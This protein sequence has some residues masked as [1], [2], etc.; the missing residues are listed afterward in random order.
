MLKHHEESLRIMVDH[1]KKNPD[2]LAVVFGGSVAKGCERANSDLDAM[3]IIT[4]EAYR[5][6]TENNTTTETIHGLCTYEGGYFDVKYMTKEYLISAAEKGSEPTRSSFASSRVMYTTD[7]EIP[8]I[9]NRIPVFQESE[10]EDKMLSFFSDFWLNYYYF[11]KSCP[12]DD[13]M[14]V[15]VINE[16]VYSIY[17]MILQQNH[18]LF[19]CN[20]RLGE[21]I[22]QAADT[23]EGIT[24]LAA[25]LISRMDNDSMDAFVNAFLQ[26]SKYKGP[27]DISHVLSRYTNDFEQWWRVPRPLIA[28]W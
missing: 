28:E 3:I 11:W 7:A 20:R 12:L 23:P 15:H 6:R 4:E 19:P 21:Y 10:Y 24:V 2:V 9:V 25:E 8:D 22:T 5:L 13:F 1:F 26:W 14:K 18:M 17:R 16:V 27:E